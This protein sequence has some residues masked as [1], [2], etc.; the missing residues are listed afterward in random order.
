MIFESTHISQAPNEPV[1]GPEKRSASAGIIAPRQSMVLNE[2]SWS[3]P[4]PKPE[5]K[6]ET[7][8]LQTWSE[9]EA[10]PRQSVQREWELGSSHV[11]QNWNPSGGIPRSLVPGLPG[12]WK[13]ADADTRRDWNPSGTCPPLLFSPSWESI[14]S[15]PAQN[16]RPSVISPHSTSPREW[17]TN[18]PSSPHTND[19]SIISS[20]SITAR[21]W[22]LLA[23]TKGQTWDIT[24]L[25]RAESIVSDCT[26]NSNSSTMQPFIS[27]PQWGTNCSR[28]NQT[29]NP[30]SIPPKEVAA[31]VPITMPPS[32]HSATMP[33][34]F[35]DR[36]RKWEASVV[37]PPQVWTAVSI[38]A[39]FAYAELKSETSNASR[40]RTT[41]AV[42]SPS[43]ISL[44]SYVPAFNAPPN[45]ITS[46]P[47]V[48]SEGW[49]L[50]HSTYN[51]SQ[52]LEAMEDEDLEVAFYRDLRR[53]EEERRRRRAAGMNT[54]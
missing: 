23:I 6:P 35:T 26:T 7:E 32:G 28:P 50:D 34:Q 13:T 41:S 51:E 37:S 29:Y 16:N 2:E 40:T 9:L 31:T 18:Y 36:P 24:P 8:Q 27:S 44:S 38:P 33:P 20:G 5:L 21:G 39:P 11:A 3:Q 53:Q 10:D 54:T 48:T 49:G 14:N 15:H 4:A 52:G 46:P 25:G 42:P 47:S 19:P 1:P 17:P 43:V 12:S 22:E 45:P 30:P